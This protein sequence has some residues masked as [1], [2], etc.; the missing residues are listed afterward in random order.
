MRSYFYLQNLLIH[1]VFVSHVSSPYLVAT[2]QVELFCGYFFVGVF[3][4]KN[5][6]DNNFVY[7]IILHYLRFEV[8]SLKILVQ[9]KVIRK[10]EKW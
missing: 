5:K 9:L 8:W 4:Y 10:S 6:G 2:A 3:S 7:A 1:S